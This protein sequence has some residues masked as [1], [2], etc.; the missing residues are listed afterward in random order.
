MMNLMGCERKRL[1]PNL[2]TPPTF[3][4]SDREE[5]RKH[6]HDSWCPGSYWNPAHLQYKST[7][8]RI[9]HTA[10]FLMLK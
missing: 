8:L 10:R 1:L 9:R 6:R 3:S 2:G 5:Q 7:A 4:L